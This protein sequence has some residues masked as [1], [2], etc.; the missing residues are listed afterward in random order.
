MEPQTPRPGRRLTSWWWDYLLIV[1]WLGLVFLAVGLPQIL[2]WVDFEHIWTSQ[3]SAD[4][5]VTLLTVVPLFVYLAT[6]ELSVG[7]ATFG[8]RRTGIRVANSDGT[9]PRVM[10][11]VVRNLI[12]VMPWQLGHM[13]AMRF[14]VT[15]EVTAAGVGLNIA[16][17]VLLA[18]VIGPPLVG[19][20]GLHDLLAGTRVV[21]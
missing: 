9:E 6:S 1:V 20:R 17:L 11:V 19:R 16:S 18:L 4:L 3:A 21:A 15:E 2:E 10:G 7:H 8:K 14:A 13:G 5:V 12:K